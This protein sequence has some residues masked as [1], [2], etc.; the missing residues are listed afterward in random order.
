MPSK[1]MYWLIRLC[2]PKH[3]HTHAHN[4]VHA[5]ARRTVNKRSRWPMSHIC[6]IKS[7]AIV[8][9]ASFLYASVPNVYYCRYIYF[10]IHDHGQEKKIHW[11]SNK[12]KRLRIFGFVSTRSDILR[13][14]WQPKKK[15]NKKYQRHNQ[16]LIDDGAQKFYFD[17]FFV[18][19]PNAYSR[20]ALQNKINIKQHARGICANIRINCKRHIKTVAQLGVK[21]VFS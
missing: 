11:N 18:S 12:N 21:H 17:F 15:N 20:V 7:V 1:N 6:R 14:D 16:Y 19:C 4:M 2:A 8:W 13:P 3:T 5:R 10:F 9:H